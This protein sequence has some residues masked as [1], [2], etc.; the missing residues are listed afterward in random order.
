MADR[1]DQL[2]TL[3]GGGGFVGRYVAQQLFKAGARVRIAQFDARKA[4]F[5]KPLGHLGQSQFVAVDIRNADQVAAAVKN[6]DAVINLV[7]VLKGDF[8]GLHVRGARNVAQACAAQGI[9]SLVHISA[10]GADPESESAYGRTKGEGEQEVRAALP[11]ATIVRPSVVFGREDNFVNRFAALARLA[12]ALPV[13][14]GGGDGLPDVR[15]KDRLEL[16]AA[17]LDPRTHGGKTYE[18][19]GPQVLTMR[20]LMEWINQTTG[21]NRMLIDIPDSLAA[22]LARAIGWL[23]GA[24]I[25]W[26]QWLMLQRD[27]VVSDGAEGLSSFGIMPTPLAAVSEGWLTAYRRHGRFAAKQPY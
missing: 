14:R 27:N 4:F 8:E 7:G 18:L 11:S 21:R 26:D 16:H 23:P 5:L 25:T 1:M 6:S 24:P 3:F 10:I 15:G 2:V 9:A 20:E 22:L 12:P 19:G 13:I 17:A